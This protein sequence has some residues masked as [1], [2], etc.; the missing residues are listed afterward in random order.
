MTNEES[1]SLKATPRQQGK[2]NSRQLRKSKQIPAVV[3]GPKIDNINFSIQEIDADRY[4]KSQ[5]ENTIFVLKSD[6]SKLNNLKVLKKALVRHPASRRPVHLDFYA[7]DMSQT[8]R[9]NVEIRFS[10]AKSAG[11]IEGGVRQELRRDVEVECLP[12]EIP[13]FFEIDITGLELGGTIHASA[14]TLPDNVKLMTSEDEAIIT[15]AQPAEE[16]PEVSADA[17]A[18][19]EGEAAPASEATPATGEDKKES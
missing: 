5:F 6:D 9:V 16:E 7:L 3:Y 12:S 4:A 2:H 15:I 1:I 10:E 11:E 17:A 14:I 18:A 8:V 19:A 13:E